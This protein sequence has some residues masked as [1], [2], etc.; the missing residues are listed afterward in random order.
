[1]RPQR[2]NECVWEQ[3]REG[4][5]GQSSGWNLASNWHLLASE[6]E[7]LR[8]FQLHRTLGSCS[9]Q[10]HIVMPLC[11]SLLL[12]AFFFLFFSLSYISDWHFPFF[13]AIVNVFIHQIIYSTDIYKPQV[14]CARSQRK[15]RESRDPVPVPQS[16]TKGYRGRPGGRGCGRR[17]QSFKA[18]SLEE[19]V[20]AG[21]VCPR[22]THSHNHM[23]T[24]THTTQTCCF[25]TV[26]L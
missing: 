17:L 11:F 2:G 14:V 10:A 15:H 3:E 12:L 21:G 1:M 5:E 24:H 16:N 20:G 18:K 22:Q 13:I 8:P 23:F 26:P 7:Q 4:Q 6:R 25:S 19:E 9:H